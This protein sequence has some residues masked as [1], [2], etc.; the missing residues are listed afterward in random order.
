KVLLEQARRDGYEQG[1]QSGVAA[2][3]S[4]YANRLNKAN[5]V[6]NEALAARQAFIDQS[7][8]LFKTIAVA[9]AE[10]LIRA[11]LTIRP[12]VVIETVRTCL[13]EVLDKGVVEIRIHPDDYLQV[14]SRKQELADCLP[15]QSEV[16][17]IP[18][19]AICA[20]G[21]LV[22]SSHGSIDAR[23]ETGLEEVRKALQ[24]L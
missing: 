20:G 7:E 6:L 5:E 8:P 9:I 24:E 14:S 22:Y 23:I 16:V 19:A 2:S 3:E 17:V 13:R 10:K 1:Y 15:G 4:E 18:D 21:C 12:E 11:E